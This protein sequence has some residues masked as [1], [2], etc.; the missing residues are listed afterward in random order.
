MDKCGFVQAEARK[1]G[2]ATASIN[3]ESPSMDGCHCGQHLL[4]GCP[5]GAEL[6]SMLADIGPCLRLTLISH[7]AR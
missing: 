5:T 7:P 4:G 6:L 3:L 2:G 1:V